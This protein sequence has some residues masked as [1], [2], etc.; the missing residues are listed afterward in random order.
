MAGSHWKGLK[1]L[2]PQG[3]ITQQS[4]AGAKNLESF[5][6]NHWCSVNLGN[7]KILVLTSAK[8]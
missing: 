2:R 6:E 8:E 4:Q 3:R 5:L 7:L 1:L